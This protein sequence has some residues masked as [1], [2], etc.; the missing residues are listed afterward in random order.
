[1]AILQLPHPLVCHAKLFAYL[2]KQE[3]WKDVK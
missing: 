3:I 2:L 1:M